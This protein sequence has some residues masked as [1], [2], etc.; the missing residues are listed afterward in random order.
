MRESMGTH[1]NLN[2]LF[3]D[4]YQG[5]TTSFPFYRIIG[6]PKYSLIFLMATV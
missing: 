3:L 5:D 4:H 1:A 2:Y 6:K